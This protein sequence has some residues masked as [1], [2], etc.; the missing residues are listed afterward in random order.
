M[1]SSADK[2]TILV[3]EGERRLLPMAEKHRSYRVRCLAGSGHVRVMSMVRRRFLQA[4][5]ETVINSGEIATISG[6]KSMLVEIIE[7]TK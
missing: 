2:K 5:N 7:I 4:G 1:K 6:R 3:C